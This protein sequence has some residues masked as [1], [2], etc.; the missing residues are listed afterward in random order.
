MVE[1]VEIPVPQQ[2][3][4]V[5]KSKANHSDFYEMNLRV[6]PAQD[7]TPSDMPLKFLEDPV[8]VR[9]TQ[10]AAIS[11][12]LDGYTVIVYNFIRDGTTQLAQTDMCDFHGFDNLEQIYNEQTEQRNLARLPPRAR[13][14]IRPNFRKIRQLTRLTLVFNQGTYIHA[15]ISLGTKAADKTTKILNSY[16]LLAIRPLD[17]ESLFETAFTKSDADI[18]SLDLSQRLNFYI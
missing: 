18:I 16:D 3:P 10:E 9:Q 4:A 14:V 13:G 8:I 6:G 2:K 11:A 7:R 15:T 5:Q 17:Q 12:I 1:A